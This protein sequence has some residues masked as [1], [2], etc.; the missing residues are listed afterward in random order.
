MDIYL[1][2]E[3]TT[4]YDEDPD[5]ADEVTERYLDYGYFIDEA[6]AEDAA[7]MLNGMEADANFDHRPYDPTG[8]SYVPVTKTVHVE[9]RKVSPCPEDYTL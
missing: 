8:C 4:R 5:V 2:M 7:G 6:E 3:I 9:V 1:L